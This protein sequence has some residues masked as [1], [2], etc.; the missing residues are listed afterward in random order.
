M[1]SRKRRRKP[2]KAGDGLEGDKSWFICLHLIR[3]V[4]V[5]LCIVA[6]LSMSLECFKYSIDICENLMSTRSQLKNGVDQDGKL[7][8]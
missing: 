6:C 1:K 4:L 7:I 5:L 3:A 8:D 2:R